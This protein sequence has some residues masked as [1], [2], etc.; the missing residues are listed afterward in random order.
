M[1]AFKQN[2]YCSLINCHYK[3]VFI[4]ISTKTKTKIN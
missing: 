3:N 4:L 1:L 2:F